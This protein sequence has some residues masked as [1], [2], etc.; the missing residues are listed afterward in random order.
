MSWQILISIAIFTLE[1]STIRLN[2]HAETSKTKVRQSALKA[3]NI[4]KRSKPAYA[5]LYFSE[6]GT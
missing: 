1:P 5:Q 6:N 3:Q 4:S 2:E